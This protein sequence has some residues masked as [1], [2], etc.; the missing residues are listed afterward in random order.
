MSYV[1]AQV[2]AQ[3]T[4]RIVIVATLCG[5]IGACNLFASFAPEDQL[6]PS[7]GD[8]D[9][10]TDADS[11]SDTDADSDTGV[12]SDT[13]TSSDR[14]RDE[15]GYQAI[16]DCDDTNAAVHPGA[17]EACNGVDDDCDAATIDGSDVC[18]GY[19][20]GAVP[21]C[22]ECCS[23]DQ[24][25]SGP[26]T[27]P[28]ATC[29]CDGIVVGDHC[30][31]DPDCTP[32]DIETQTES[33]GTCGTHIRSRIC[34]DVGTWSAFGAWGACEG[35]FDCPA[36]CG[37]GDCEDGESCDSCAADCG[38]CPTCPCPSGDNMCNHSPNTAGCPQTFPGGY[39]DPDGDGSFDGGDWDQGWYEYRDLCT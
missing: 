20:C 25:G 8:A 23:A 14:D 4:F 30:E 22:Q 24:C 39:C 2:T 27:C 31:T 5:F 3:R 9:A 15:D 16:D 12:D 32:G 18:A 11:D 37:N 36:V 21:A 7:V 33:C 13:D 10:D 26:W 38:S 6:R 1:Y 28:D 17:I 35:D 29:H 19:C 34:D